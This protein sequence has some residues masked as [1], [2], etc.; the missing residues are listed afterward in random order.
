MHVLITGARGVGKSTLIRRVTEALNRPMWGFLTK[1]DNTLTNE[2][3]GTP[4]Y[5]HEVGK[6]PVQAEEN[7]IGYGGNGRVSVVPETF[8]R[9]AEKLRVPVPRDHLIL[10]DELGFMESSSPEFCSAVLTLL[11]GN[12]PIIAAVREKDTPFLNAL[13][14]HPNCRCFQVTEENREPLYTE[15]LSFL[16]EQ[17]N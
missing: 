11:E 16:T 17:F 4:V 10:M 9:W 15:V 8:D 7:L 6:A 12:T 2:E 3:K 13:R 5:I 14:A 1:R